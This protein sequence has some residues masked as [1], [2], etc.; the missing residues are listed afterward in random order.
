[1]SGTHL[2]TIVKNTGLG[3]GARLFFICVR[4][5]ITLLVTRTIGSEQYG[6]FI[7]A[8]TII[9]I[10]EAFAIMG[11]QPAMIKFVAQY[12]AQEN[13][14]MVGGVIRFGLEAT[15]IS[16][17]I[18]AVAIFFSAEFVAKVVFHK[19]NLASVLRVMALIIPI[20]TLM[21]IVLSSLQGAKLVK[22]RIMVEQ[23]FMP[24]FRFISIFAAFLLGYRLMGVVWAWVVT[25]IFGL[26]LAT[27]ILIKRIPCLYKRLAFRDKREI[28]SYSLPIMFSQLFGQNINAIGILIIGA[29]LPAAQ[30]G[31][32]GVAMRTIPFVLIPLTSYNAIFSPIISELF[33]MGKME[34]LTRTYKIG[35]KWVI[36]IT[37]PLFALII[38]FSQHIVKIFGPDFSESATIMVIL[39]IGHM[40]NVGT[41]SSA[42]MLSMTGK[43]LYNL[44]NAG[45]VCF[46]NIILSL[47][48]V[49]QYGIIGIACAYS[50]SLVLIQ[51]LQM[52]EV[53]YLYR[54]HPYRFEHIKPVLSCVFSFVIIYFLEGC[55]TMQ[56]HVISAIL[57]IFVFLCSYGV[58][59]M[60]AGLSPDDRMVLEKLRRNIS[61]RMAI[62]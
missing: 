5:C 48:L 38:F 34:E 12:K 13:A 15:L 45:T 49:F 30:T 3:I 60:L 56:N 14:T 6:I 41:G 31:I 35:N 55:L 1:M 50:I 53:W 17:L 52:G 2:V 4:F 58:F 62:Y 7:L 9:A 27:I 51:L 42:F 22:Y 28:V 39:L 46:L 19:I 26:I 54:I 8:I 47:L 20:V 61:K 43:T 37:L 18:L 33:T 23:V 32:Y 10:V 36:T 40:V 44:F 16:S 29:F 57:L 11:L 59:L 21:I 25:C 24:I